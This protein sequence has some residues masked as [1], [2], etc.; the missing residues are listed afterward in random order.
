MPFDINPHA[1]AVAR[2][3]V[4][5]DAPP[6][7]VWAILTDIDSWPEWQS[8]VSHAKLEGPLESGS[9]FRWKA[10]GVTI[11]STLRVVDQPHRIAW[12]GRARGLRARHVW[13]LAR[14]DGKTTV[15]TAESFEG[16]LVRLLRPLMQRTLQKGLDRGLYELKDVGE[17]A[18]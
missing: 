8:S 2:R 1:P 3:Q 5:V 13:T 7:R 15:K 4:V 12:A 11:V 16:T 17:A 6:E 10:G 9:T 14:R 18:A